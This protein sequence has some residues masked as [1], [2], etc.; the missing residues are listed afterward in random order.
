M[1]D[2]A[3]IFDE[4]PVVART[5]GATGGGVLKFTDTGRARPLEPCAGPLGTIVKLVVDCGTILNQVHSRFTENSPD[6]KT[7][8]VRNSN[9]Q[10]IKFS[11]FLIPQK[12]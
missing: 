4:L 12:K 7:L 11:F 1:T 5:G 2:E 3:I 8:R 10:I 6:L 9:H